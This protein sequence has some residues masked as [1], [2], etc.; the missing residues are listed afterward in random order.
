MILGYKQGLKGGN[1]KATTRVYEPAT[2]A[3]GLSIVSA[4]VELEKSQSDPEEL[5]LEIMKDPMLPFCSRVTIATSF[6]L[7]F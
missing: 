4:T 7:N 3:I 1:L 6:C 5:I 2:G